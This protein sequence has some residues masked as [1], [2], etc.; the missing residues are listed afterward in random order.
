MSVRK[1]VK[2]EGPAIDSIPLIYKHKIPIQ[3]TLLFWEGL[4][5]GKIYATR[6]KKCGQVYFPPQADCPNDMTSDMEWI[7]LPKNG[8]LE[9]F[10]K[11]YARPQGFDDIEPYMIGIATLTNGVRV[12]G[13]V[14]PPDE[15]CVKVGDEVELITKNIKGRYL[16]ILKVNKQCA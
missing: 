6:C 12:M 11:V 4:K 13:W 5:E 15:K 3:K 10:T 2:I 9:A 14:E 1:Y 8:V 16:I 7:E